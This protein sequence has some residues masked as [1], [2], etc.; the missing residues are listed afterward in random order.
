MCQELRL[1]LLFWI[2]TLGSDLASLCGQLGTFL[3]P[4]FSGVSEQVSVVAM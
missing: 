2:G 1:W 4:E 3:D